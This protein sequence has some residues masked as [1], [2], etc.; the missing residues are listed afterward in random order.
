MLERA[1]ARPGVL[2]TTLLG[3]GGTSGCRAP[4]VGRPGQWVGLD[5]EPSCANGVSRHAT[6]STP[7]MRELV[8]PAPT[9]SARSA[10]IITPNIATP[11]MFVKD[12]PPDA[13][14]LLTGASCVCPAVWSGA[15]AP[16]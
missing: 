2:G 14:T 13:C 7:M 5:E 3:S 4:S 9:V 10:V 8:A 16:L 11:D 15:V 6:V 12:R 1:V